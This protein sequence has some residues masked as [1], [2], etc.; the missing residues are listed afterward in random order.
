MP[1]GKAE[2]R[3]RHSDDASEGGSGADDA[4]ADGLEALDG[5]VDRVV[6]A[7]EETG[8]A[9][10]RLTVR[11]RGE[12][13]AVGH[14]VAV[15][16]GE[17]LRLRGRWVR[18]R[19]YGRQ[20]RVDEFQTI[21]PSTYVGIERYLSSGLVEGIGKTMAKRLVHAFGLDTLEIIDHE[22]ERLQEVEGIGA[23]RSARIREAW[24]EQRDVRDIMVF[25]QGHG[26][27]VHHATKIHQRYGDD[28]L[29]VVKETPHRLAQDVYGIGFQTADRIA[30]DVGVLPDAPE[31]LAAGL[32]HV[33]RRARD[34]G[35][36]FLWRGELLEEASKL[37]QVQGVPLD[38]R[39]LGS[40]L[41][42]LAA[43]GEVT[44]VDLAAEPAVYLRNLE[45]AEA[46]VARQLRELTAQATL[47]LEIDVARALD[48]Y[49][50]FAGL[51]LAPTQ[52]KALEKALTSKVLVITGGPGTGK[53]T[54]VR[55]V[56]EILKRK[57]QRIA[58]AAPT[59]RAAKRLAEA[60]GMEAKTLHRLL[61]FQP[62]SRSFARGPSQPLA[63]DLVV[64]D[65]ASML[66]TSLAASLLYAV[67]ET[68][69]LI[70]VGDVDQLPSIGPGRVLADVIESGEIDVVRLTEIFRQAQESLIVVN[71][72]R[73]RDGLV[74]TTAA[75]MAGG[76]QRQGARRHGGGKSP[77]KEPDFFFIERDEPEAILSTLCH[78]V[79][80][81]IPGHF[82]LDPAQDIQVLTPM[83]RG[84]L[85]TAQLNAELQALLNPEGETVSRGGHVLRAGDR[86]MQRRNNYDL[87]VF[88]GDVGRILGFELQEQR[89]SIDFEGQIVVYPFDDLDEL[90]LA[91]ACS[92]HKSQGSEYPCV[93]LPLH[94]QHWVLLQ[95]NLLYTAITRGKRLVVIV[96][97]RRAL[98]QATRHQTS[99][100]RRTLLVERLRR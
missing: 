30:R 6:F 36:V 23:V 92:I 74:P 59:G 100:R 69:R 10:V 85:G 15:Q 1:T 11:G 4:T 95:R 5:V 66:D 44:I 25:L 56:V 13:T 8:W 82:G 28:A 70:L 71:A 47:P 78:L 14:L 7:N 84:L 19:K 37:L 24:K 88:N 16:P 54:L 9:V 18:D 27:S 60:T 50:D 48:W 64:V 90:G 52:R 94:T 61:E 32:L 97:S 20:F 62:E 86:V 76:G 53:T 73:V 35:H 33:L 22:P 49:E 93:V 75:P 51:E 99:H 46:A 55:G 81:R 91:Y 42:E 38:P 87:G 3:P 17:S 68:A 65:E 12:A 26:V 21:R 77:Q 98:V 29:R 40:A 45:S 58:L 63:A 34:K 80:E 57:K 41:A 79:E 2:P 67:P 39:D 96:G 43:K 31:R 72:H 89:A 83:R